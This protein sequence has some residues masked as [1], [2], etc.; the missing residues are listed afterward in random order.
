MIETR[1]G[2]LRI[3]INL[4]LSLMISVI[5]MAT[6]QD[7][8]EVPLAKYYGTEVTH[9]SEDYSYKPGQHGTN[10]TF[11]IREQGKL[12]ELGVF[13][14]LFIPALFYWPIITFIGLLRRITMNRKISLTAKDLHNRSAKLFRKKE[15]SEKGFRSYIGAI[16]ILIITTLFF[17]LGYYGCFRI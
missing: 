14:L 4:F 8:V 2:M 6:F 16:S 1:F 17:A 15:P 5:G 13:K 10:F 9:T 7:V 12:R 11:F 3:V